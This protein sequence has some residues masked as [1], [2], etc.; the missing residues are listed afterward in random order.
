MATPYRPRPRRR[1]SQRRY[2][3]ESACDAIFLALAAIALPLLAALTLGGLLA[4]PFS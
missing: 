1:R 2:S 3:P 4:R